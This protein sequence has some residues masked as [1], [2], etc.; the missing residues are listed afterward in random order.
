[1]ERYSFDEIK[2]FKHGDIFWAR[3]DKYMVNDETKHT[4][5]SD[6]Y[7]DHSETVEWK[8]VS[9]TTHAQATFQ[10][11]RT[12]GVDSPDPIIFKTPTSEPTIAFADTKNKG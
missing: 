2:N 11:S 6:F 7:G 10:V 3:N 5:V 1:M 9:L 4:N 12:K 8:G